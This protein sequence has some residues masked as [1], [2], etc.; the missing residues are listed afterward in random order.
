MVLGVKIKMGHNVDLGVFGISSIRCLQ[1][2][3]DLDLSE[4]DID[5]DVN[6][7]NPMSFELSVQCYE[8]DKQN[9]IKFRIIEEK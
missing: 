1:C 3:K 8:C 5:C 2:G 7:S 6:S 4:I 9:E